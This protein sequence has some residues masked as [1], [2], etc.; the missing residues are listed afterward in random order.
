VGEGSGVRRL[1]IAQSEPKPANCEACDYRD[2]TSGGWDCSHPRNWTPEKAANR[3][4]LGGPM[5][6]PD[7]LTR[8]V[9]CALDRLD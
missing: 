5:V 8:P 4:M 9:W 1:P 7:W 2:A 3:G 6:D